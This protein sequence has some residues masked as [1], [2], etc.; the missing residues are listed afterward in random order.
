MRSFNAQLRSP[1]PVCS[2]NIPTP[3]LSEVPSFP[4]A[5]WVLSSEFLAKAT[6]PGLQAKAEQPRLTAGPLSITAGSRAGTSNPCASHQWALAVLVR[7]PRWDDP[8][9]GAPPVLVQIQPD[10]GVWFYY[11]LKK[12]GANLVRIK[13][14]QNN[15][16]MSDIRLYYY[17]NYDQKH[18][19]QFLS[20]RLKI[21]TYLQHNT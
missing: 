8:R 5:G 17:Q 21:N 2:S 16:I 1:A 9:S 7:L 19:S 11:V 18:Q 6:Q 14:Q 20:N 12:L 3:Q 10:D 13:S 15:L 4:W